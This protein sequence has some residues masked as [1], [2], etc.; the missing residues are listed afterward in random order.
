MFVV[1]GRQAH[2]ASLPVV[3]VHGVALTLEASLQQGHHLHVV[4]D[5][6]K[7]HIWTVRRV[8]EKKMRRGLGAGLSLAAEVDLISL[9]KQVRPALPV[10]AQP[11]QQCRQPLTHLFHGTLAGCVQLLCGGG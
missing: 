2:N 6:E 7:T 10:T 3:D 1:F 8:D 9:V 5:N 4:L 11:G